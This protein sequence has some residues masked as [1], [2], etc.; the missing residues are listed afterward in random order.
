MESHYI[1]SST[2]PCLVFCN[3][4]FLGELT[5]HSTLQFCSQGPTTQ[6]EIHP[7]KTREPIF[8]I[9]FVFILNQTP[10]DGANHKVYD[11][12][13]G[14]YEIEIAPHLEIRPGTMFD[15]IYEQ[16]TKDATICV[17]QSSICKITV[18]NKKNKMEFCPKHILNNIACKTFE[19][20]G[21]NFFILTAKTTELKNYIFVANISVLGN[22]I[23]KVCDD[24]FFDLPKITISQNCNDFF[25]HVEIC[26]YEI[27]SNGLKK[28]EHFS[29]LPKS[30]NKPPLQPNQ[31][32]KVFFECI[33]ARN[34]SLART[35]L[36]N[37][38][39]NALSDEH[40]K[41]F[42]NKFDKIKQLSSDT[43]MLIGEHKTYYKLC[44]MHEKIDNIEI[45]ER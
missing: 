13:N 23:Q 42:F 6:V 24:V 11:L 22:C 10:K 15:K 44:F 8:F 5:K 12:L 28:L 34:Y 18:E 16:T 40:L 36:S 38:L 17:S 25:G 19:K 41:H 3:K 45:I 29:T 39:S 20:D 1:F 9:P 31:I 32:G 2:H 37:T 4:V 43:F 26:V 30:H 7:T 14:R 21:T 33:R 35:L 27:C